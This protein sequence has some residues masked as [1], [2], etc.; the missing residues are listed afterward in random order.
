MRTAT[1]PLTVGF[2]G[3]GV[4][5]V[6][7]AR[8]LGE[9]GHRVQGFDITPAALERLRAAHR[10]AVV[11]RT[12]ADAA[13]GADQIKSSSTP[14]ITGRP[15]YSSASDSS[16]AGSVSSRARSSGRLQFAL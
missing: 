7:M 14:S 15:W 5:G 6:P 2:V 8:H 12:A 11:C 9:A 1:A 3:L 4:M 10:A 16:S 13:R